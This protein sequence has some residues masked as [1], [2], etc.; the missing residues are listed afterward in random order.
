[1]SITESQFIRERCLKLIR[2][3]C[4]RESDWKM[5]LL[6]GCHA[7]TASVV[8]LDEGELPV[9]SFFA[10]EGNWTLYTTRRLIGEASGNRTEIEWSD[11]GS[12]DF[13]D[14]K[15]DLQLPK[16][17]EATIHCSRG[18]RRFSYESGYASMAPIYYFR[19]WQMKWPVWRETYRIES[20]KAGGA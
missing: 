9:V 4:M 3:S 18:L 20:E 10:A 8:S 13:G 16:M 19:F 6:D 17:A 1:M 15:Q 14:F 5:T 7:P 12:I 11:F 2:K